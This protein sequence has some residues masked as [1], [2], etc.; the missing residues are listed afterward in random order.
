M[1]EKNNQQ[2]GRFKRHIASGWKWWLAAIG[3]L[4][5]G[6]LAFGEGV[7]NANIGACVAGVFLVVIGGGWIWWSNRNKENTQS[8]L[9]AFNLFKFGG[10]QEAAAMEN[11]LLAL[12]E[13]TRNIPKNFNDET[14]T[15]EC[16]S[17]DEYS[18]LFKVH[19][20]DVVG[21]LEFIEDN[22]DKW[23]ACFGDRDGAEVSIWGTGNIGLSFD[24]SEKVSSNVNVE[25]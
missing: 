7:S 12:M 8:K 19:M 11:K 25:W 21:G 17:V 15:V 1:E 23:A 5:C 13:Q 2:I 18:V 24:L 14:T 9:Y 22:A 6:I 4:A 20:R 16:L 10:L 3:I